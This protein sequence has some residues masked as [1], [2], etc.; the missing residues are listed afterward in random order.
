[1]KTVFLVILF[2]CTIAWSQ[3]PITYAFDAKNGLP[4]NEVYDL[5][6]DLE[7]FIWVASNS[8]LLRYNGTTFENI[9][10]PYQKG[11][12]VFNLTCDTQG[13]L[14][15]NNLY[16]Q[17]FK[18][19]NGTASLAYDINTLLKGD[20]PKFKVLENSLLVFSTQGVFKVEDEGFSNIFS[21]KVLQ[22]FETEAHY[23]CLDF[24]RQLYFL[25]KRT[26]A[27]EKIVKIAAGKTLKKPDFFSFQGNDYLFFS[28]N[29]KLFRIKNFELKE[30]QTPSDFQFN[31]LINIFCV[32]NQIWFS[33]DGIVHICTLEKDI[34]KVQKQQFEGEKVSDV[35]VDE[36]TNYWFA[37]LQNGIKVSPNKNI[38]K[39][40]WNYDTYG[41][42]IGSAPYKN[43]QVLY[44][45]DKAYIALFDIA[46]E[47][48]KTIKVPTRRTIGAITFDSK[49]N[50]LYIGVN[51][52]ESYILDVQTKNFQPISNFNVAKD[53]EIIEKDILY[54]TYNKSVLYK[55]FGTTLETEQQITDT[56]GYV[57]HYS[58]KNQSVILCNAE[59]LWNYSTDF[60]SKKRLTYEG[61]NIFTTS[62]AET[63]DGRIWLASKNQGLFCIKNDS[64]TKFPLNFSDSPIRFLKSYDNEL[65]IATTKSIELLNTQTAKHKTYSLRLGVVTPI[66]TLQVTESSVFY[67]S[68]SDI[69]LIDR[70]ELAT[71]K[72]NK[73]SMQ[74][75][76]V[77]F[78]DKDTTLQSSY[79]L[80]YYTNNLK[81]TFETNSFG[82]NDFVKYKYRLQGLND[83]WETTNTGENSVKY[84]SVPSGEYIFEI[85]PFFIDTLEEGVPTEISITIHKPIWLR[86]WFWLFIVIIFMV[87]AAQWMN[88]RSN[89]KL[90]RKNE[91]ISKLLLEKRMAGL[92]LENLRSQ[93]N[94]HF[95]FNALNSIQEYI[96]NNEKKLASA[97][98]VKFS[99]LMRLYLE[100]SKVNEISL[101]EELKTITLYLTLEQNRFGESF[102]YDIK[103]S[104]TLQP[105]LLLVPSLL[106]QPYIENA[107]KHGLSHKKGPKHLEITCT[108]KDIFLEVCIDDNGIGRE[109]SQIINQRNRPHHNSFATQASDK[110]IEI[111][112]NQQQQKICVTYLDK[113]ANGMSLGTQV[114]ISIPLKQKHL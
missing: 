1:M 83:D 29:S 31:K 93:M 99:R 10:L 52:N 33:D 82:S 86:W 85:K 14:W 34:L 98:L 28:D 68:N 104:P 12:S 48:Y 24:N 78:M 59:G 55:N 110:R 30:I 64:L 65:W 50:Q 37:T 46:T 70:K 87:V 6:Q 94:P 63:K 18:I 81:F 107:I 58:P 77:A 43:N 42:I 7:G 76:S 92:Q 112:N 15:C 2:F 49:N 9:K 109:A 51:D 44:F 13:N 38:T 32:A 108:Q 62:I 90:K 56:R 26:F 5:E 36:N 75:T 102:S 53:I 113:E 80:P 61:E 84:L 11:S 16:G 54:T 105:S 79:Q 69:Y 25:N 67:T 103:V 96:V 3:N 20:L 72:S 22:S 27:V 60:Q 23:L 45:T 4:D 39:I 41:Y 8:G 17:V 71:V 73:P 114:C 89:L 101:E 57:S 35:L 19:A 40:D 106:L 47:T 21:H 88:Y 74:I 66:N 111:V 95:I 100:H 91:E 97:Y